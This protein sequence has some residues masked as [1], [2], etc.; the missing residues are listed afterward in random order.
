MTE[1]LKYTLIYENVPCVTLDLIIKEWCDLCKKYPKYN[2][3]YWLWERA[4]IEKAVRE[5]LF[6][7]K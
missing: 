5:L 3:T 4:T 6:E 2:G 7:D 1:K